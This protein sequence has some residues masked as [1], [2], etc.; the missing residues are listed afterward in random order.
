MVSRVSVYFVFDVPEIGC[1]YHPELRVEY[2]T[3]NHI[4]KYLPNSRRLGQSARIRIVSIFRAAYL[5]SLVADFICEVLAANTFPFVGSNLA[6]V[7]Q[8]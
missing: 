5:L 6:L 4:V 8:L 7:P 2:P 3:I 1:Q